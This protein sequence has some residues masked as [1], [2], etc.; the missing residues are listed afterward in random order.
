MER[1]DLVEPTH[2]DWAAPSLLVPK[3][4]GI[5]RLVVDYRGLNKQIEKT[6]RPL[7]RINEVNDSLEGNMYFSNIDLLS[8]YFQMALE[9]ES[10]NVTAFITPLGLYKWKRLPMG[11]ASAP[12]AFQYLMELVF[13]GLSYKVFLVYIDD[14]IV[15]GRNFEEHHKRLELVFQRLLKNGLKIK[16]SKCNFFQK[17]VSFLGHIISE[18]GVEVDPEKVIAVERMNKP[19]YLK[20]VRAF[21]DLVGII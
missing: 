21:L 5:Y 20:D 6:C 12:G 15:F 7:Q 9:E 10:Q 18:S 3:K 4:D 14:V 19:S 13:A 2:S 11:L 16:G 17:R 8:G 1:D